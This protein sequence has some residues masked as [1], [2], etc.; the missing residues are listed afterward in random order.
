[1]H[2]RASCYPLKKHK[3]TISKFLCGLSKGDGVHM[4]FGSWFPMAF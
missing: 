2:D 4:S 3:D 1:M